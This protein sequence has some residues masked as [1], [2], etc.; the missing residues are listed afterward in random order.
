MPNVTET[1][2]A[3]PTA[4]PAPFENRL[5]S[6]TDGEDTWTFVYDGDGNRIKQINPDGSI[7]LFLGGGIYTVEDAADSAVVSK[8]YSIAGQRLAMY[9]SEGLQFLLTDHLGSVSA[10]LDDTGALLSQQRYLPFGGERPIDGGIYETDF[11]YTGQRD[12]DAVGLMDYNARWYDP[13]L[14]RFVS[15]DG[16]TIFPAS[17]QSTNRYAYVKNNPTRFVDPDG[18]CPRPTNWNGD[19]TSIVCIDLFISTE[20][21]IFGMGFGDYRTFD[22]NSSTEASRAYVYIHLDSDGRVINVDPHV[23]ESCTVLGCAGPYPEFN[24]F[25]VSQSSLGRVS[26]SWHLTN[27]I[28]GALLTQSENFRTPGSPTSELLSMFARKLGEQI[29]SIDG[30][31]TLST[32]GTHTNLTSLNRDPYPSLEIYSYT[33]RLGTLEATTVWESQ[34]QYDP[35]FG[36]SPNAPRDTYKRPTYGG[37]QQLDW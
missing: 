4:T 1:P 14:G 7:T 6:L 24:N 12:L 2:G 19:T 34:E 21:I 23:N 33:R 35:I 16:L 31:L 25:E 37:H 36:L 10:V 29:G 30:A 28:S 27:G 17:S 3:T 11:G 5:S 8:Y 15:P 20:R 26:V 18:Y 32:D 22:S 9:N 13:S